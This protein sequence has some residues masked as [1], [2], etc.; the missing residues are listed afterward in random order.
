MEILSV[1]LLSLVSLVE[2]EGEVTWSDMPAFLSDMECKGDEYTLQDCQ[3]AGWSQLQHC[4]DMWAGVNCI[5]K[6]Y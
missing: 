1:P 6:I 3:H 4:N 2:P 5:G